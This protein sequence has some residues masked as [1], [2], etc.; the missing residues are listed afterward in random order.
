MSVRLMQGT[1]DAA[2]QSMTSATP[3][4]LS[5]LLWQGL[6][7][8][9]DLCQRAARG[10]YAIGLAGVDGRQAER[11]FNRVRFAYEIEDGGMFDRTVGK[12][13]DEQIVAGQAADHRIYAGI[14]QGFSAGKKDLIDAGRNKFVGHLE[15]AGQGKMTPL[16]LHQAEAAFQIAGAG[17]F[18]QDARAMAFNGAVDA[19]LIFI[20]D[21]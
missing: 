2:T 18:P 9:C 16:D 12:N 15:R 7:G 6:N 14:E 21:D 10:E 4:R 3:C 1:P 19:E 5:L 20:P 17:Q 11:D 8:G 13:L